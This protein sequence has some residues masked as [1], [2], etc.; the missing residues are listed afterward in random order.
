MHSIN[1]NLNSGL[2]SV[3]ITHALNTTTIPLNIH[4]WALPIYRSLINERANITTIVTQEN[5]AIG[6]LR[7]AISKVSEFG[8]RLS[9]SNG[10]EKSIERTGNRVGNL[11]LYASE[12]EVIE[13]LKEAG[14]L[15]RDFQL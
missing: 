12:E 8:K 5:T 14:L 10:R 1:T 11:E 3:T 9:K 2:D 7:N 15:P 4:K 6:Y 13:R